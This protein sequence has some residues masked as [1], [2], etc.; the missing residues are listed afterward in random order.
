MASL[1]ELNAA[2]LVG[3]LS[4][5]DRLIIT[6]TLPGWCHAA[7]MSRYLAAQSL[8]CFDYAK[9]FAEPLRDEIVATCFVKF[10]YIPVEVQ[11]DE[12]IVPSSLLA[13]HTLCV[14]AFPN[15][16]ARYR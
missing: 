11:T 15:T 16:V 5:F 12:D 8:R 2:K 7:G 4:C 14:A 6:D 13:E 1:V 10:T 3:V 9:Q